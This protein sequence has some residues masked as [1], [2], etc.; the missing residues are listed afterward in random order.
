MQRSLL[1][2]QSLLDECFDTM[3]IKH[4]DLEIVLNII[5][6]KAQD[7]MEKDISKHFKLK[8]KNFP[9]TP[10]MHGKIFHGDFISTV[11]SSLYA[12]VKILNYEPIPCKINTS[13]AVDLTKTYQFKIMYS[14]DDTKSPF[15]AEIQL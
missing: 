5:R 12:F 7:M 10:D 3:I 15:H 6:E 1:S 2:C 8:D 11:E 4:D 14:N 9:F 13:I